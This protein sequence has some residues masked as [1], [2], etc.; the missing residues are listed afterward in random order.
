VIAGSYGLAESSP[1]DKPS[2]MD[3]C[4]PLRARQLSDNGAD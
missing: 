4:V 2:F 3:A 1:T